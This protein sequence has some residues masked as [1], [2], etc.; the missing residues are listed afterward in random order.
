MWVELRSNSHSVAQLHFEQVCV[1]GFIMAF[2]IFCWCRISWLRL[3]H[4]LHT[5]IQYKYTH[6]HLFVH[7]VRVL[8]FFVLLMTHVAF[9][10][11]P[12]PSPVFAVWSLGFGSLHFSQTT[13]TGVS[14]AEPDQLWIPGSA[15]EWLSGPARHMRSHAVIHTTHK[16]QRADRRRRVLSWN[17]GTFMRCS[18]CLLKA[19]CFCSDWYWTFILM[20]CLSISARL[21]SNCKSESMHT[22]FVSP[23][24]CMLNLQVHTNVLNGLTLDLHRLLYWKLFL[25]IILLVLMGILVNCSWQL[26]HSSFA[27]STAKTIH[28]KAVWWE[29]TITRPICHSLMLSWKSQWLV[30]IQNAVHPWK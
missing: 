3:Q 11:S 14:P 12:P 10:L 20:S 30:N 18:C 16:Q 2:T 26:Q 4:H 7:V 23:S 1:V 28:L 19:C 22:E 6:T 13:W 8:L 15:S 17:H 5:H 29:D 9:K 24:H 27:H 21:S 25:F